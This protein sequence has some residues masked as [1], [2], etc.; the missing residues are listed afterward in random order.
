[1]ALG[2]DPVDRDSRRLQVTHEREI[3]V[4]LRGPEFEVVVVEVELGVRVALA[5]PAESVG[6]V[7]LTE[8]LQPDRVAQV[9]AVVDDL[10]DDVPLVDLAPEVAGDVE[11]VLAQDL[12]QLGGLDRAGADALGEPPRQLVVPEQR[13]SAHLLAVAAGEV[14]QLVRGREVELAADRF[15]RVPLHHVLGGDA[16]ELGGDALAVGGVVR[17][18]VHVHGGSDS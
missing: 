6:D 3:P 5:G 15:D 17:Q 4:H 9:A 1:V 2:A 11:D 12:A 10:V 14:D 13:V 18:R 7:P 8:L 16:G